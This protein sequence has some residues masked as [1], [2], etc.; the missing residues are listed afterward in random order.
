MAVL[1]NDDSCT[2]RCEDS[3]SD[4]SHLSTQTVFS[5]LDHLIQWARYKFQK[6][7]VEK[8]AGKSNKDLTELSGWHSPLLQLNYL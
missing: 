3:A 6:L 7:S 8:A 2:R 5:M 4:L 1:K